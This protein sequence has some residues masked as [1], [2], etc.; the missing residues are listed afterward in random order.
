MLKATRAPISAGGFTLMELMVVVAILTIVAT[1]TMTSVS[2][3]SFDS[4]YRLY[5][6]D[7]YSSMIA[8]RSRAIDDQTRVFLEMD[9]D[10]I[11]LDWI[12][13]NTGKEENLWV[14]RIQNYGGQV[15]V[16]DVCN[17]GLFDGVH[18]PSEKGPEKDPDLS[19][20]TSK[21]RLTFFPDGTFDLSTSVLSTSGVTMVIADRRV[22]TADLALIELFPG[23][24]IRKTDHVS[25]AS[26]SK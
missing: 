21:Q 8:A 12:N 22:K 7:A 2:K 4:A 9:K 15:L 17:Y 14:H 26:S 13:P 16:G 19:C 11:E 1:A 24:N 18:A 6:D 23:G 20:T 3:H 10:G 25:Q 5:V